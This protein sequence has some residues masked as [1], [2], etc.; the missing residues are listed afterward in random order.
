[1]IAGSWEP[2]LK[3]VDIFEVILWILRR[4][5]VA[6]TSWRNRQSRCE[7]FSPYEAHWSTTKSDGKWRGQRQRLPWPPAAAPLA[8]GLAALGHYRLPQREAVS[9]V[10]HCLASPTQ[11]L[12][13]GGYGCLG[14]DRC[15]PAIPLDPPGGGPRPGAPPR[16]LAPQGLIG[17]AQQALAPIACPQG[18]P[19]HTSWLAWRACLETGPG[20][21]GLDQAPAPCRCPR[22]RLRE[23]TADRRAV[24]VLVCPV[25][26]AVRGSKRSS[27]SA[28]W[29][30]AWHAVAI[31]GGQGLLP[32]PDGGKRRFH[33]GGLAL[34]RRQRAQDNIP[35]PLEPRAGLQRRQLPS[36]PLQQPPLSQALP[37]LG[38]GWWIPRGIGALPGPHRGRPRQAHRR[39][40]RPPPLDL[41]PIRAMILARAQLAQPLRRHRLRVAGGGTLQAPALGPPGL[42]PQHLLGQGARTR[43]PAPIVTPGLPHARPPV[44]A[45]VQG[46]AAALDR[47]A[48]CGA[49]SPPKVQRASAD[50]RRARG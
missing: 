23:R 27:P 42:D 28:L 5:D 39:L 9:T 1:M 41:G 7:R 18:H 47:R 46:G 29:G 6:Q 26:T 32:R 33:H 19:L 2:Q 38:T 50:G 36:A 8:E 44:G 21:R 43:T 15:P 35:T 34:Q 16:A 45:D 25:T 40:G 14:D 20:A 22:L 48:G 31:A 12:D 13:G 3:T 10:V 11:L 49:A 37:P 24:P 30:G 17:P 4:S